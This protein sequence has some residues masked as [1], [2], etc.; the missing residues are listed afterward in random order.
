MSLMPTDWDEV[1]CVAVS[2]SLEHDKACPF[3]KPDQGRPGHFTPSESHQN[4]G[5]ATNAVATEQR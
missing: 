2:G 3:V 4:A 5:V 1:A